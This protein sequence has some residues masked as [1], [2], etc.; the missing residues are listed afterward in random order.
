MK[1]IKRIEINPP[2]RL[3]IGDPMYL[4]KGIA[5]ELTCQWKRLSFQKDIKA[6]IE[7]FEDTFF[8]GGKHETY[9]TFKMNVLRLY[10]LPEQL[11]DNIHSDEEK[12]NEGLVYFPKLISGK[13]IE[14]GCDTASFIVE[15][16]N[17][18]VQIDTGADGYY[19]VAVKYKN[20]LGIQ[21]ELSFDA[22]MA[23]CKDILSAFL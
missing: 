8:R 15:T 7:V 1:L 10:V 20:K 11:L 21:V 2:K 4:E 17:N 19:G 14:L 3:I 18:Y 12:N 6:E 13:V 16:D 9:D 22:A 5:E 23:D